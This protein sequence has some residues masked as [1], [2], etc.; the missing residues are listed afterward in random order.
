MLYEATK[1]MVVTRQVLGVQALQQKSL[2]LLPC[3]WNTNVEQ[4]E[5]SQ[6]TCTA[7]YYMINFRES[8]WPSISWARARATLKGDRM[9]LGC[10]WLVGSFSRST[11][12]SLSMAL[13]TDFR[14]SVL[15]IFLPLQVSTSS[16]SWLPSAVPGVWVGS[17][18]SS[19]SWGK[20]MRRKQRFCSGE[21]ETTW[22]LLF[23]L[24][25]LYG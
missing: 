18:W 20:K 23:L 21:F 12:P 10:C 3:T 4:Q 1:D 22:M 13:P 7:K 8:Y 17:A 19:S 9:T 5:T 16:T 15:N 11:K 25:L 24:V 6:H 2:S 14:S